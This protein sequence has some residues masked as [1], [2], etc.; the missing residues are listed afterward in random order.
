MNNLFRKKKDIFNLK[1]KL[2]NRGKF[3]SLLRSII[4]PFYLFCIIS[5][6]QLRNF[7]KILKS[8]KNQINLS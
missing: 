7:E 4:R 6:N 1:I 3:G 8:D 2:N 5:L